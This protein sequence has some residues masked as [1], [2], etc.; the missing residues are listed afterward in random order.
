MRPPF[1]N[2]DGTAEPRTVIHPIILGNYFSDGENQTVIKRDDG[3]FSRTEV[4]KAFLASLT[5][6]SES[7]P[8]ILSLEN[9]QLWGQHAWKTEHGTLDSTKRFGDKLIEESIEFSDALLAYIKN[10][11]IQNKFA[12]ISEAG[13]VVWSLSAGASNVGVSLEQAVQFRLVDTARGTLIKT[14]TGH[15]Y[16]AWRDKAVQIGMS[17]L[18]PVLVRDIDELFVQGFVPEASPAMVIDDDSDDPEFFDE[19]L[20]QSILDQTFS[21]LFAFEMDALLEGGTTLDYEEYRYMLGEKVAYLFFRTIYSL[22]AITGA[23]FADIWPVNYKKITKRI[24]NAL[25]DHEDGERSADLQ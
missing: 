4:D 2:R 23:N 18:E 5:D 3:L 19:V 24:D 8:A 9:L 16:P 1:I 15:K 11:T 22:R 7:N 20:T 6:L 13:D 25:I 12:A 14:D 17:T 10:P 21:R